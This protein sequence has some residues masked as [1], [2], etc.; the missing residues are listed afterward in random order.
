M[1][2][3]MLQHLAQEDILFCATRHRL[4]MRITLALVKV[5]TTREKSQLKGKE[6]K[7]EMKNGAIKV[8]KFG[9]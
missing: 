7:K 2:S 9:C 8:K 4:N 3:Q 1:T 5:L 6:I